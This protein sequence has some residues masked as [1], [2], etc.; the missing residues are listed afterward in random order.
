[1]VV[2]AIKPKDRYRYG[3]RFWISTENGLLLKSNLINEHNRAVEQV[4]FTSLELVKKGSHFN[5]NEMPV[6]NDDYTMLRYHSGE[7]TED[8]VDATFAW[9]VKFMP[10]GFKQQSVLKRYDEKSG[11][12]SHQMVFSDGLASLSIFIEKQARQ[13]HSGKASMGAVNAFIR[14]VDDYAI[15]AIGEVPAATVQAMAESVFY[16]QH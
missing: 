12:T 10:A 6:I 3:L 11:D 8:V 14:V 16:Q 4:M 9:Q 1:A 2:V 15:T 13:L 5:L 7:N